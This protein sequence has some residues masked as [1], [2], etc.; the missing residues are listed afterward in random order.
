MDDFVVIDAP[1][2]FRAEGAVHMLPEQTVQLGIHRGS[3]KRE[4]NL[5][6]RNLHILGGHQEFIAAVDGLQQLCIVKVWRIMDIPGVRIDEIEIILTCTI[7]CANDVFDGQISVDYG[8][9]VILKDA[10]Q[11]L[12]TQGIF[13]ARKVSVFRTVDPEGVIPKN[14]PKDPGRFDFGIWRLRN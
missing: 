14:I 8:I 7:S 10:A 1:G 12:F 6:F 3:G 2:L 11:M 13:K 9:E 4:A 5:I